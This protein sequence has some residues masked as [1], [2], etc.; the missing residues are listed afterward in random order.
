MRSA[1][2]GDSDDPPP[3]GGAKESP[4]GSVIEAVTSSASPSPEFSRLIDTAG[5]AAEIS[6]VSS[7]DWPIPSAATLGGVVVPP[8]VPPVP[9]VP[10]DPPVPPVP[11]VPPDA[12]VL[13]CVPGFAAAP[14]P[15]VSSGIAK[16]SVLGAAEGSALGVA[17]GVALGSALG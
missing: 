12:P 17:L 5:A 10:P 14:A 8:P 11:P 2:M 15:V 7:G 1:V 16:G 6:R 13:V 9:P 3:D 4:A